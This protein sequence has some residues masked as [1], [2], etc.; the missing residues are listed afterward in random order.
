M[1]KVKVGLNTEAQLRHKW[2]AGQKAQKLKAAAEFLNE[3][4]LPIDYELMHKEG[5][6]NYFL[7]LYAATYN[8]LP[9]EIAAQQRVILSKVDITPLE[10]LQSE[11]NAIKAPFCPLT[12]TVPESE[13]YNVYATNEKQITHFELIQKL[14]NAVNEYHDV[15]CFGL[16]DGKNAHD[17]E[18][19]GGK[20]APDP[21]KL[22]FTFKTM[23]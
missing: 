3:Y 12:M 7:R 23:K 20:W 6:K 18:I 10:Y 19:R 5:F 16:I 15:Y 4:H 1:K 14:C 21:M 11:Y 17:I 2:Q 9:N 22:M 13:D 8:G